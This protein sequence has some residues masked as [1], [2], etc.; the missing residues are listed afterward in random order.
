[1]EPIMDTNEYYA[2]YIAEML[3]LD[4]VEKKELQENC[5]IYVYKKTGTNIKIGIILNKKLN[6]MYGVY[7]QDDIESQNLLKEVFNLLTEKGYKM[8]KFDDK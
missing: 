5:M 1:M 7:E 3:D 4:I 2:L 8:V 6:T